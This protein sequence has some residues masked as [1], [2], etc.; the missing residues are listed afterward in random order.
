MIDSKRSKFA[1]PK[2][3]FPFLFNLIIFFTLF[4]LTACVSPNPD[5]TPTPILPQSNL[6]SSD[7]TPILTPPPTPVSPLPTAIGTAVPQPTPTHDPGLAEWTIMVYLDAD[8]NLEGPGLLDLNEMEAAG[9]SDDVNVVVQIDRALGE[10][11]ADGDWT[12]TR[13]YLIQADESNDLVISPP[14]LELGERNMGD[15]QELADFIIWSMQQYPA[16]R[17][18]LVVWDH[19]AGWNGIAFDDDTA[20]FGQ[21]DHISLPDMKSA[22]DVALIQANVAKLDVIGFD[23]CLMGQLDVFQAIQPY[24]KY[25]VGSEELTPGLGWDYTTLLQNLYADPTMSSNQLAQQMVTDF[26]TH[27]TITD[28]DD[29]VTMSAIDLNQL[30][31]L[32]NAVEQLAHRITAVPAEVA[33]AV[34]DARSGAV[35]FARVYAEYEQYAAIDLHHF[36]A[37]LAQRSADELLVE[38]AE[39]VKTAVSNA[40]ITHQQ[41][42]GIK[43][44]N[45]IAIYF[46]RNGSFYNNSYANITA[47][48]TWNAFLNSYHKVGL[49]AVPAPELRITNVLRQEISVQNPAYMDFEIVGRDIENVVLM[50][51]QIEENGRLR[52]LEYDNLIPEATILSDGSQ[53]KEWRDGVHEDFYVWN[54]TVTYLYDTAENGDFVVM[55]PTTY[56]SPLFTVQGQYRRADTGDAI[57]ANLVFNNSTGTLTRVWSFQA[58]NSAGVA[59]LMPQP[60]DLFQIYSFYLDRKGEIVRE[61]GPELQFDDAGKVYFDR[62]PLPNGSYQFG[63]VAENVSGNTASDFI[64]LTINNTDLLAGVNAYLDPYL[65]FQFLYPNDWYTPNYDQT[66]LYTSQREGGTELQITIYPNLDTSVDMQ[67]LKAQTLA[68]FGPVTLLFEDD[69]LINEQ[70]GLRTAYGYYDPDVGARTGVFFTFVQGNTGFVVDV[71]STVENEAETITAVTQIAESWQFAPAG[72]G[73]QPGQ[74]ATVDFDTFTVA[75]PTDFSYQEFNGWQRFGSGPYI[76]VALR[77]QPLLGNLSDTTS[78]LVADASAGVE[79]FVAE[80]PFAFALGG[81][82]WQRTNFSYRASNATEDGGDTEIW[83]YLMVRNESGQAIVAWVE[84]PANRYNQLETAVFLTMIAD[85]D[86]RK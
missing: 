84:A 14:V 8:N 32:T 28:P 40:V 33:S 80:R 79:G 9:A 6:D 16:N 35:S 61:L 59:E 63:F 83:G 81:H 17:Y 85:M 76:F 29:F 12:D 64:D 54:T 70:P 52:L 5:P 19:G 48:P 1:F 62:R 10:S 23:A 24:A 55:W 3:R 42:S 65:G 50:G 73:L 25:G 49:A 58:S 75:Q 78:K 18:A 22:L 47:M 45:G 82:I 31:Q 66:L 13:R 46:P 34:G 30:P 67:A 77:T 15:P 7:D 69:L 2:Y 20:Q 41:A 51:M 44:S 26:M 27:Y 11:S 36:A 39:G 68:Q 60:G 74:W 71:D 72:F 57:E 21:A 53:I 38:R 37:I 4:I 43:N 56:N 86:V